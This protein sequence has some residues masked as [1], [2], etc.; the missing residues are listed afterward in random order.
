VFDRYFDILHRRQAGSIVLFGTR[1]L[2]RLRINDLSKNLASTSI[3]KID[4]GETKG[5]KVFPYRT[6][7]ESG[8]HLDLCSKDCQRHFRYWLRIVFNGLPHEASGL[9]I[10]LK[11]GCILV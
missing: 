6:Y 1:R 9:D 11:E 3:V 5:R 2:G 8:R 10:P 7:V 4:L